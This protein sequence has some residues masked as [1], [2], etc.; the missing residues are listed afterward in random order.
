MS[1]PIPGTG[2]RRFKWCS[3]STG[4]SANSRIM[5]HRY[6]DEGD[7]GRTFRRLIRRRETRLWR[8]EL[9]E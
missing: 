2:R 5:P 6:A 7:K 4:V 9:G 3:R 1:D 8:R